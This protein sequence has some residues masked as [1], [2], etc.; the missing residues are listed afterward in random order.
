MRLREQLGGFRQRVPST[1][2]GRLS[3]QLLIALL[4][5]VVVVI[6]IILIPFPGPGWLIVLA[7]LAIWS[8]EFVWAARLL[9]FTKGKLESWWQWLNRQHWTVRVVAGLV[10]LGFVG[11]VL[12]ATVYFS[13]GVR[14]WAEFWAMVTPG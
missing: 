5:A 8:V 3:W 11:A 6:G 1:R 9:S 7:G 4:G 2:T 13:F 14:S 12:F 10:G